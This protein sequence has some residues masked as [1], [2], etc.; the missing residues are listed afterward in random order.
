MPADA[1]PAPPRRRQ[2]AVIPMTDLPA[3]G[4]A[5]ALKAPIRG[6]EPRPPAHAKPTLRP[7]EEAAWLFGVAALFALCG[8]AA[9]LPAL[10]IVA[11]FPLGFLAFA[12][13]V[14]TVARQRMAHG[15]AQL[16]LTPSVSRGEGM[17]V[18]EGRGFEIQAELKLGR[19]VG[20]FG[21]QLV[22]VVTETLQV[23]AKLWPEGGARPGVGMTLDV[24]PLRL[25]GGWLHGFEVTASVA[26]RMFQVELWLP[27]T[28][29]V[30]VLPRHMADGGRSALQPTRAA[31]EEQSDLVHRRHRGF[32]L[33]IRELRDFQTGDPFKH[34]AW[35]ASARRGKLIAREFESDL[36]ISIWL[37]VDVSPSMFWGAPGEARIDHALELAHDLARVLSSGRDRVGLMVHDHAVRLIVDPDSGPVQFRRILT[38]LLEVPHLVHEDRTELTDRELVDRVGQWFQAQEGKT[39]VVDERHKPPMPAYARG[40]RHHIWD[41]EQLVGAAQN[42]LDRMFPTAS[43]GRRPLVPFASYA[44]DPK[45]AILRAFARYRGIPLPRDPTPR[46]GGQAH[47]LEAA[48]QALLSRQARGRG[49]SH[50]LLPITD[51]TTADDLDALRR[52]ALAARRH[53]HGLVF[54]IPTGDRTLAKD[55]H[56]RDPRLLRA[57]VEVNAIRA[58]H[59]LRTAEAIL[60]PAGAAFVTVRA[61]DPLPRVLARLRQVA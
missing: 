59:S 55:L 24:R 61:D 49:G 44:V 9:D 45:R 40:P 27:V 31:L 1:E 51:L 34:I 26:W 57:L 12:L 30:L 19:E 28:L 47:G 53:R 20:L 17:K 4:A 2:T 42:V 48:M 60:R 32:G 25:G 18:W 33:E 8:F 39:F 10:A 3:S 50:L 36:S 5:R 37:L 13:V 16:E 23:V 46:P 43:G 7:T 21:V 29:E 58:A 35:R 11:A 14:A 6:H 38:A 54:A 41:E 56:T 52:V 15:R 22:P